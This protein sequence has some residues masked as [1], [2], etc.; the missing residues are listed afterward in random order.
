M[1]FDNTLRRLRQRQRAGRL[2]WR[3]RRATQC[4]IFKIAEVSPT[5][6]RMYWPAMCA[7][8][9]CSGTMQG[10]RSYRCRVQSRAPS[11]WF[12]TEY[13]ERLEAVRHIESLTPT[14]AKH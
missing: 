4:R 13:R 8:S 1:P 9:I 6:A 3:D 7:G 11:T 10:T 12:E 14:R 5:S 2:P